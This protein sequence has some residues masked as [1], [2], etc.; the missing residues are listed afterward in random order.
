MGKQNTP[1]LWENMEELN[2]KQEGKQPNLNT[3]FSSKLQQM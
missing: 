1:L 2:H 3:E